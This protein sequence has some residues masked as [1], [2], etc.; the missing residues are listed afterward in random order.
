MNTIVPTPLAGRRRFLWTGACTIFAAGCFGSFGLTNA[1]YDW[2]TRVSDNKWIRWVVF[3]A[4]VV[5]PVYW[6]FIVADALV[7]NTIEF[8]TGNN[9]VKGARISDLGHGHTLVSRTTDDPDLVRHEH[10]RDGALVRVL[11]VRRLADGH[12]QLLDA[13]G[14]V[15]AQTRLERDGS[16]SRL[17]DAGLPT[18][19][20]SAEAQAEVAQAFLAGASVGQQ[21]AKSLQPA[22][23]AL[24]RGNPTGL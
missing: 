2:N 18:A 5:L 12:V 17:D 7:L 22:G 16:V 14:R 24:A 19:R 11:Y 6:I 8:W 23:T 9:P 21:I 20:L 4:L 10:R 15:L 3:L 1:L 13:E